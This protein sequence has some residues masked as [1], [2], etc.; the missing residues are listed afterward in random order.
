MSS[1]FALAFATAILGIS[2]GPAVFATIGRA[3]SLNLKETYIFIIGIVIGDL[4]FALMAMLGL[5]AIAN[6]F[7]FI[8]LALKVIGGSYLI[9]LGYKSWITAKIKEIKGKS[10]ESRWKLLSSGF[11]LTASNPKDLIFFISF[12][13]A[14]MNLKDATIID[15]ATASMVIAITFFL[16]L[17]AYA[18]LA[19]RAR[20][21]FSDKIAMTYLN[22]GAGIMLATVGLLV[23][24]T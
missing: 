5:A 10:E 1:L 13:P 4:T 15:I 8:F 6:N 11:L 7:T 2:P 21:L 24:F 12:L 9:Y 22:R 18:I 19:D 16:T 3:L 14:F 23:I 20:N 17:S